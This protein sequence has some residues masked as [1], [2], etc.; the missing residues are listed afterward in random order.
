M[1]IE[2]PV[3]TYDYLLAHPDKLLDREWLTGFL[4]PHCKCNK[5]LGR[6]WRGTRLRIIQ[7]PWEFAGF[8]ILMASLKIRS[9][10]EIGT[11]SG[12]SF[13]M[14]DS[15]LRATVPGYQRSV[16]YDR[17]DKMRDFEEYRNRWP[18]T[19]F[20]C[21][22]SGDMNLAGETFDAAFID[23]RHI[24]RWVIQDYNKVRVA[25]PK[26]IGFHDI[27][28]AKSTVRNAWEQ[29]KAKH[30]NSGEIIDPNIPEHLQWGIGVVM[31]G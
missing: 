19:T 25:Q 15:Y 11:S 20:R 22:G 17:K 29:I 24:E 27:R 14:V 1:N 18:T 10:L 16:G 12:G 7:Y 21:Q 8:L 6:G 4:R 31:N 23:A 2:R 3:H 13:L 9:Y 5:T 26:L 28:L 30:S